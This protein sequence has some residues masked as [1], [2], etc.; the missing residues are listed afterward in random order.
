MI[1]R[2]VISVILLCLLST[3]IAAGRDISIVR[4][5]PTPQGKTTVTET[6]TAGSNDTTVSTEIPDTALANNSNDLVQLKN[7]EYEPSVDLDNAEELLPSGD[8]VPKPELDRPITSANDDLKMA[9]A[10]QAVLNSPHYFQQ[11]KFG[12]EFTFDVTFINT[13]TEAWDLNV[14]VMQYTGDKLERDK[15]YYYDLDKDVAAPEGGGT[16]GRIVYPGESI[17]FTL[18]MKAPEEPFHED[19]KYYDA[20][21]LVKNWNLYGDSELHSQNWE[22]NYNDGA[23]GMFCPVYFYIYVPE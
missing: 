18:Q 15:K 6:A 23:G 1:K 9:Y 22:R 11:M 12:E 20:Y 17:R 3:G 2:S 19:N 7:R 4:T 10:C 14:D 5:T 16:Q 8:A 21:T 13:G